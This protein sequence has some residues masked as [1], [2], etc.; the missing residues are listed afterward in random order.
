MEA[1][2]DKSLWKLAKKRVAFRRHFAMYVLV[3]I[4]VWGVWYL[5]KEPR[6]MTGGLPWPAWLTFGWGVGLAFNYY[7]AYYGFQDDAVEREYAK[8]ARKKKL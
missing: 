3:N 6:M 4:L 2:K 1:G 5:S 7:E 8:L